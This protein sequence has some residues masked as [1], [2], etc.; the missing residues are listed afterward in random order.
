M[1]L[2]MFGFRKMRWVLRVLCPGEA[3]AFLVGDGGLLKMG[4]ISKA[5]GMGQEDQAVFEVL[6]V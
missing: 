2:G 4:L 5:V 1:V 6:F 3:S